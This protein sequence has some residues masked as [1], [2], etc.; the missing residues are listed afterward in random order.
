MGLCWW[1]IRVRLFKPVGGIE[2]VIEL[3]FSNL[4]KSPGVS[5]YA[6]LSMWY[7]VWT[8]VLIIAE[9]RPGSTRNPVLSPIYHS[10]VYTIWAYMSFASTI[11]MW[12]WIPC[13]FSE[14]VSFAATRSAYQFPHLSLVQLALRRPWASFRFLRFSKWLG[15]LYGIGAPRKRLLL[16]HW[17]K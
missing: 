11:S 16:I 12:Y 3:S 14:V 1:A 10:P 2:C 13:H 4:D 5:R 9:T 17:S 7:C 15:T 8:F 6:S